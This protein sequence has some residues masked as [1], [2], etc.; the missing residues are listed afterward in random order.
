MGSWLGAGGLRATSGARFCR[1]LLPPVFGTIA[2][3]QANLLLLGSILVGTALVLGGRTRS[4][5]VLGGVAIGL[6]AIVKV[7]PGLL[8][9]PLALGRRG[10]ACGGL[11]VGALGCLVVA[12]SLWPWAAV[13]SQRLGSL[14]DPD[15]YFTNQS[16][17]GF[18]SR[19]VQPTS[20]TVAL[21]PGPFDPRLPILL[22]TS[23]FGLAAGLVLWR[24]RARLAEPRGLG[25]GIALTLIVGLITA[26]KGSFWTQAIALVGVG[27][28]LAVDLPDL[29]LGRLGRTD[30]ALMAFWLGGAVVQTALWIEP[31]PTTIP[32]AQVVT[33]L[34]SASFFGMLALWWLLVRRLRI[35]PPSIET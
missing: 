3:G 35:A 14:F 10:A 31:P 32:L 29:R 11:L 8:L 23:A 20:R 15:P 25:L 13:G 34:T 2:N 1:W 9:F 12:E 18:I 19:L 30:L 28:L 17:N 22:L 16:I 26:P 24:A 21:W 7:F 33:I 27:L 4:R 5:S 6:A